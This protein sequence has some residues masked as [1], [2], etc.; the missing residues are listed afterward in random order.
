MTYKCSKVAFTTMQQANDRAVMINLKNRKSL[1]RYRFRAYKCERCGYYHLTKMSKKKHKMIVDKE[2][3]IK[4]ENDEREKKFIKEES[5][6]WEKVLT[7]KEK[8]VIK[9]LK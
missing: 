3:R 9:K 1:D 7:P 4:V 6:H 8:K 2:F 5:E